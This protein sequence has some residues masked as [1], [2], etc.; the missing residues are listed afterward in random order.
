MAEFDE[1]ATIEEAIDAAARGLV[2][3]TTEA[4]RQVEYYSLQELFEAEQR[5]AAQ[6]AA[7]KKGFGIRMQKC[8]SQGTG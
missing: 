1:H 3:K 6:V 7:G 8:V 5:R 4:D 2:K